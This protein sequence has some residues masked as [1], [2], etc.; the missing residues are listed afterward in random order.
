MPQYIT[1]DDEV[2]YT[3]NAQELIDGFTPTVGR[4]PVKAELEEMKNAFSRSK[5]IGSDT[6]QGVIS[7][8]G[9]KAVSVDSE[10]KQHFNAIWGRE[11]TEEEFLQL[12]D[13]FAPSGG[14]GT[15]R[16]DIF[17][18]AQERKQRE[19]E[20]AKTK[21][22]RE[23]ESANLTPSERT[24]YEETGD[25]GGI[26]TARGEEYGSIYK[27][28]IGTDAPQDL[29]DLASSEN[30]RPFEFRLLVE[31]TPEYREVEQE[32]I[33]A[34]QEEKAKE[35]RGFR[36][37]ARED[38]LAE[39]RPILEER[40]REREAKAGEI[41]GP[42]GKS[43]E[44]VRKQFGTALDEAQSEQTNRTVQA[45]SQ[46]QPYGGSSFEVAISRIAQEAL[47]SRAGLENE[48]GLALLEL[49]E[50]ERL[51]NRGLGEAE[52]GLLDSVSFGGLEQENLINA[53]Q[54]TD[55]LRG[56]FSAQLGGLA[57][58]TESARISGA[59]N[60]QERLLRAQQQQQERL[61]FMGR[62]FDLSNLIIGRSNQLQDQ[63]RERSFLERY[64]ESIRGGRNSVFGDVTA[65]VGA[66][67]SL[68]SGIGALMAA[69]DV[70]LKK[71]VRKLA[72]IAGF[73]IVSFDWNET[74]RTLG[75]D[76]P[77]VRVGVIAQDLEKTHPELVTEHPS[78]YKL[79]DYAGLNEIL[80][81]AGPLNEAA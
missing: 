45:L 48:L 9:N 4:P 16:A 37:T 61:S 36:E 67:G 26:Q 50:G 74:A 47:K 66:A 17:Q 38:F 51:R 44:L 63:G 8:V 29:L 3:V 77:I 39:Q 10:M 62:N 35:Q 75:F 28:L 27:E 18:T 25:L 5:R 1:E 72:T 60:F 64:L 20:E 22:E 68:A 69:S 24:Q 14:S 81:V 34:K 19:G 13:E 42:A 6:I 33:T 55:L 59:Q 78:G 76:I 31:N 30:M 23:I 56:L 71:N 21:K 40:A 58:S 73:D 52:Q 49:T 65:G 11:P 41:L 12:Q 7:I 53:G 80:Q 2:R 43:A 32:K 57:A 79:V 70:R 46:Y 54:G 15:F